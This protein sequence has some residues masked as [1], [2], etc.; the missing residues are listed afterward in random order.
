MHGEAFYLK[1]R[2]LV[3]RHA[4]FP[5]SSLEAVVCVTVVTDNPF[6]STWRLIRCN[7]SHSLHVTTI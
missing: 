6:R 2:G 3:D 1:M 7:Y 4:H 5:L